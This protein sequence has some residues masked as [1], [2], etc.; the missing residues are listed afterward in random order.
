V[1][2]AESNWNPEAVRMDMEKKLGKARRFNCVMEI[3]MKDTSTVWALKSKRLSKRWI[4]KVDHKMLQ[5]SD[6]SSKEKISS[7]FKLNTRAIL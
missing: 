6:S 3:R 4:A 2:L 7:I 5:T 1:V